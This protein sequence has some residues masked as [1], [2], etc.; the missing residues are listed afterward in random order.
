M[1]WTSL[2]LTATD[3]IGLVLPDT[4]LGLLQAPDPNTST[5]LV[6][7]CSACVQGMTQVTPSLA[8]GQALPSQQ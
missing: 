5:E 7:S 8:C 4:A 2:L 1:T 6:L 3:P